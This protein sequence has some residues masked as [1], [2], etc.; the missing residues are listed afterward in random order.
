M[1][2]IID[3]NILMSALISTNSKTCDLIFNDRIKLFAPDF[4]LDEFDKHENE[5]L[6]KSKLS[7]SEFKLFLSLISSRIEF[8]SYSEF[9][10]FI[11]ISKEISPDPN[12]TEYFALALRL[13]CGIW[14]NDKKLKEQDQ[15]KVYST[16]ELLKIVW[17]FV[18]YNF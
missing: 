5:I 11:S 10:R 8:F 12:D 15:V 16:S 13:N 4:L 17:N 6:S 7:E 9:K 3:A 1:E 14:S 2:L 18:L